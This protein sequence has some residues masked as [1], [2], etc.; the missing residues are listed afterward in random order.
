MEGDFLYN[1]VEAILEQYDI[2]VSQVTKGRGA[3]VCDTVDGKKTLMPFQGF[4]ERGDFLRRFLEALK[5]K[6]FWAEQIFVNKEGE[7]VTEDEVTGEHF[8]LKDYREGTE[9]KTTSLEEMKQ[10]VTLLASFHNYAQQVAEELGEIEK[11]VK[12]VSLYDVRNRHYRELIKVK[13]HIHAKYRKNDFERIYMENYNYII[14]GAKQAIEV[15]CEQENAKQTYSFCHGDFNQHNV[16]FDGKRWHILNFESLILS[17]PMEDL[18]NFVRKMLEKNNWDNELGET[19]IK[20]YD[21]VRTIHLEEY[22]TLYGL[23]LFPEKFWKVTN[24]YMNSHKA[25]ISQRDIEKLKKVIEQETQKN[26]FI[27]KLFSFIEE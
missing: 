2:E 16:V 7:A 13:N 27:E 20:T 14:T 12:K 24:H 8:I 9:L 26:E 6:G 15:L 17:N 21:R 18:A 5:E 22:K 25:W 11:G 4:K 23:F 10:A 19:L 3:Y 1:Q